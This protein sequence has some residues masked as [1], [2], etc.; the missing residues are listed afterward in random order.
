[1][2]GYLINDENREALEAESIDFDVMQLGVYGGA[3]PPS[4]GIRKIM[5]AGRGDQ[6]R[7]NSCTGFA[8]AHCA[9]VC[10]FNALG[11]WRQFNENWSYYEGQT[12]SRSRG[13]TGDRGATIHGCV[14]GMK[15]AGMLPVDL[16]G[17]G[18]PDVPYLATYKQRMPKNAAQVASQYRI[19]YS[20]VLKSWDQILRFLQSGQGAVVVGAPW[21]N[22]RPDSSGCLTRFVGG[23]GGHA[24]AIVDWD[25]SPDGRKT[26][27]VQAN[28]HGSR[29]GRNGYAFLSPNFVN[30][31]L[32][33][34]WTVA[35]GV[36]DLQYPASRPTPTV[37]D[38]H[39]VIFDGF[40]V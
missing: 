5:G 19:G 14:N 33:D 20:V 24:T 17:D 29:W 7:V 35:I 1:M 6:G 31:M 39:D 27:L 23:G 40:E 37:G 22:Y 25:Y 9:E 18:K 4:R 38:L 11:T 10:H 21:G 28:S 2:S 8:A 34:R 12:R 30:G 36:S 32:R 13:I 16:N 26:W 3:N 15:Q